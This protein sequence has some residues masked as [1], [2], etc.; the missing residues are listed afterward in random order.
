MDKPKYTTI[1]S[2]EIKPLVSKEK[3]KYLAMASLLDVGEFIPD[4]D[5]SVNIDLLP[6]AFNACV[7][8]RVNKNG[9]V[10]DTDTAMAMCEHFVNKPINVEHNRDRVVGVVLSVGFSEFGTDK[11]LDFPEVKEGE[12]SEGGFN[13]PFNITLGGV[14][15][16]T[17]NSGLTNLIESASDPTSE[18]Y[19]KV[20][21]SWELGFSDYQLV[22]LD[23]GEKNIENAE[24]VTDEAE[25]GEMKDSLKVYGGSGKTEEGKHIYRQV[26][27]DVL[28]LGIGLTEHPAADVKG[29]AVD[30]HEDLHKEKRT[31]SKEKV[32]KEELKD[33]SQ[34]SSEK[35][36][37]LDIK[38]VTKSKDS[39]IMTINSL[40]D[41]T[42]ESLKEL[43]ASVV[44]DFIEEGLK[45]ASEEYSAEK[46]KYEDKIKESQEQHDALSTEHKDL[47]EELEKV[48]AELQKLL[49]EATAKA[50]EEKFNQRMSQ[51]DE[52]YE[53]SD[54]DRKVI[55]SDIKD[56]DKKTFSAY[57]DK[58]NILL[59]S[60]NKKAL[61]EAVKNTTKENQEA[62]E[63]KAE[64]STEAEEVIEEVM[65][66][67]E[68]GKAEMPT[69][70]EAVE[71]TVTDKYRSAFALEQFDIKF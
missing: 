39:T 42:D 19:L 30:K 13:T 71:P 33:F 53:L 31:T 43:S 40:K 66:K 28:P 26:T 59:N 61:A 27:E 50:A 49:E 41:I 54:E 18:N 7:V 14:I 4:V 5:T 47:T 23:E 32:K 29:V 22:L 64:A 68:E 70:S 16:K 60:K 65:E 63:E 46:T 17:V 2:S 35:I 12:A 25:I 44:S 10:V 67:A 56:A 6:V 45:Q 24:F 62:K 57:W 69:S 38:N 11:P 1:F 3:D 51:F 58:M 15:W 9:D 8:N 48:K 52:E 55:A 34:E 21:A 36:S 20:S 37:Q